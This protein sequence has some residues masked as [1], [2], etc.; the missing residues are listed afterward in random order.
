MENREEIKD[1]VKQRIIEFMA[2]QI[3]KEDSFASLKSELIEELFTKKQTKTTVVK[4]GPTR[5]L[6][7]FGTVATKAESSLQAL[8]DKQAEFYKKIINAKLGIGANENIIKLIK[9]LQ[10]KESVSYSDVIDQLSGKRIDSYVEHITDPRLKGTLTQATI[11]R[12]KETVLKELKEVLANPFSSTLE[13]SVNNYINED[14]FYKTYLVNDKT[15]DLKFQCSYVYNNSTNH[16]YIDNL[17]VD[18]KGLLIYG[19]ELG[20]PFALDAIDLIDKADLTKDKAAKAVERSLKRSA[21]GIEIKKP[22]R[23]KANLKKPSTKGK[24]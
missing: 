13:F 3:T 20:I 22:V 19:E 15:K 10:D 23:K 17:S 16:S 2:E 18:S 6:D 9:G 21:S 5:D 8:K 7:T 1:G 12:T 14:N 4:D 11:A 24:K